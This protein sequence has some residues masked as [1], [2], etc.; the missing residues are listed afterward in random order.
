MVKQALER[1][2]RQVTLAVVW[3]IAGGIFINGALAQQSGPIEV[4]NGGMRGF[5]GMLK[6]S[7]AKIQDKHGVRYDNKIFNDATTTVLAMERGELEMGNVT[8]QHLIRAID[9]GIPIVLV[10]GLGGGYNVLVAGSDV[11]VPQGDMKALK[12]LI[13]ERRRSGNK[14]KIGVPTGSQQHLKLTHLLMGMG[15]NPEKDVD[16]VNIPFPG[17]PRALEGR[18]VDMTMAVAPFAALMI[19]SGV[20]RLFHHVYGPGVGRW[21][22]GYAV[23]KD[24]VEK[25]PDLVQRIVSSHVEALGSLMNDVSRQVELE[26][27]ESSFPKPAIEL[28]QRDFVKLTYRMSIADLKRTAKQMYDVGWTKSDHSSKVES[29]VDFRFLE[30]ATGEPR[31]RLA[32]F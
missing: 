14:L 11:K 19:Q 10:V 13:D 5:L 9:E 28:V 16:V 23:R 15:V 17:H 8:A 29:Y 12:G 6:V 31:A 32:E 18:H 2:A 7:L 4:R 21:E 22:V 25:N 30:K 24:L 26:A 20:G 1:A 3:A 27:Q